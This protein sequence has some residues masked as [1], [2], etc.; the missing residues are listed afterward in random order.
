MDVTIETL[1]AR[2]AAA[3]RLVG[4][5]SESGALFERL[6]AWAGVAGLDPR[7]L[8]AFSLSYDDPSAVPAEA[9]RSDAC[10]ELPDDFDPGSLDA[11]AALPAEVE[12]RTLPACRYAVH[13]LSGSYDGIHRTYQRLFG[14]W[15]PGSGEEVAELPCMEVYLNDCRALPEAELETDLCIPLKG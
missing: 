7:R 10:L 9:L 11:S 6:F 4:P 12:V 3:I 5:Y 13:R 15:L 8:R 1:P 2:R 14:D